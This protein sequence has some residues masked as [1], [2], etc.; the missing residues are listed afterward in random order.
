MWIPANASL[1]FREAGTDLEAPYGNP[2]ALSSKDISKDS[3]HHSQIAVSDVQAIRKIGGYAGAHRYQR[4]FLE[5]F[6]D[7]KLSMTFKEIFKSKS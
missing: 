3:L 1:F 4:K 2:A 5:H 7:K 6:H